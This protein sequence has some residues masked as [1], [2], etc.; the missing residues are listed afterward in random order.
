VAKPATDGSP[1]TTGNT[2]GVVTPKTMPN[3]SDDL[4]APTIKPETTKEEE[5]ERWRSEPRNEKQIDGEAR[6]QIEELKRAT[7]A[8]DRQAATAAKDKIE[9]LANEQE[10]LGGVKAATALGDWRQ[11]KL[12]EILAA[13]GGVRGGRRAPKQPAQPVQPARAQQAQ[14][15]GGLRVDGN[16]L[17]PCLVGKYKDIRK[18]C[19]K[20]EQAHHIAPD[21]LNRTSSRSQGAKG[22]GRI[23]GMPS[24]A[25]GPAI[26]LS[27][28][29]GVEGTEHNT[30]HR[31]DEA[32]Q[33]AA[34]RTDNGPSNTLP[35]KE[36]I[37]LSMQSAI[38]ARPHCKAQIEAEIK[39]AYPNYEKDNRSM[40]GAGRPATGDAKGH[41]EGGGTSNGNNTRTRPGRKGGR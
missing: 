13:L 19:P 37:P 29:A 12:T 1:G 2:V 4:V 9:V 32:I 15:L 21:T 14:A 8:G 26:C 41:L 18:K 3:V 35:V 16:G 22:I 33:K 7:E 17:G 31:A 5:F 28:H 25:D 38:N 27:G 30:A 10:K 39:K 6:A 20:G 34:K 11:G 23:P 24:L 36:A 40:N